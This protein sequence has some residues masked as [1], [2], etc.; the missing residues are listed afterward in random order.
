MKP[1]LDGKRLKIAILDTGIDA[2]Q[3]SIQLLREQIK[4][5]RETITPGTDGDP[6]RAENVKSFV[7]TP[8]E[9]TCGHGTHIAEILL[10]LAPEAD[11][12][13]AK[14]SHGIE[15]DTVEQIPEVS[16]SFPSQH[17]ARVSHPPPS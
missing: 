13:I 1:V 14:I 11:L 2:E 4:E 12:Y 17:G 16:P 3:D 8:G 15:V 7:G 5:A 10:K 6:I 9:D